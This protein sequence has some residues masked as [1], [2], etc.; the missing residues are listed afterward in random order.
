M[1]TCI[2][3][4]LLLL[5]TQIQFA[6][7]KHDTKEGTNEVFNIPE[8]GAL[9]VQFKNIYKVQ[10]VAPEN[11][12]QTHYK[13]IDL[14]KDDILMTVNGL[15]IKKIADLENAYSKLK[16]GQDLR[17]GIKRNKQ[18]LVVDILKADPK[19]LPQKKSLPSYGQHS[20]NKVLLSGLE[21]LII[22]VNEKPMINKILTP[23]NYQI[24]K[25]GLSEGDLLTNMNGQTVQS[26]SQFKSSWESINP[27]QEV[28]LR[29]NKTKSVSFKK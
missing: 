17:L 4:I 27:G 6:Q 25:A 28:D 1:K 2:F 10:F 5:S 21:V 16:I 11:V 13:N 24:K 23:D 14:R 20:E 26:F 19:D 12:R 15:S 8:V 7:T 9:I 29:F 3:F 18:T 22:K